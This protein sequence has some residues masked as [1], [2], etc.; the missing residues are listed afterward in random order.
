MDLVTTLGGAALSGLQFGGNLAMAVGGAAGGVMTQGL[1]AMAKGLASE[2]DYFDEAI[3]VRARKR[4]PALG[5]AA[6][7]ARHPACPLC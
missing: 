1:G 2:A 4:C 6:C 5:P 3:T 7:V